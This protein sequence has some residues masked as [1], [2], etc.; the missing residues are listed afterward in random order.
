[1]GQS[2]GVIEAWQKA[3][4]AGD[5]DAIAELYE[6]DAIFVSLPWTSWRRAVTP[7]A[8]RGPE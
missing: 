8:T 3:F 1:M 6:D 5:A 4:V 7:F 2:I